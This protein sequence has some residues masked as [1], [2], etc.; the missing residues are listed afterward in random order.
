MPDTNNCSSCFSNPCS[1]NCVNCTTCNCLRLPEDVC[2]GCNTCTYNGCCDCWEC[3][4]CSS[5]FNSSSQ[6]C[7][8]CSHCSSCCQCFECE[9]CSGR[10]TGRR[11]G[12]CN[13]CSGCCNCDR[14]NVVF[15]KGPKEIPF[16]T[17]SLENGLEG[18]VKNPSYRFI[19]AE[20][21][22]AD[23]D[24]SIDDNVSPVVKRWGGAIVRDG[25][26][27]D[28]G[29]E[30]N[31]APANG[32]LFVKQ[33]EEICGALATKKARV[34]NSCGLHVHIDARDFTFYDI[35][36]L[37]YLYEKVEKAIY[38]IVAKSRWSSNYSIPCGRKYIET[39][40]NNRLPKENKEAIT[41]NIYG[42]RQVNLAQLKN[43]KYNGARYNGLNLHSWVY[44]GTI[45]ARMHHGTTS[46]E[47]IKNWGM[48][49]AGIL[50]YAFEHNEEEIKALDG[51]NPIKL[52]ISLAKTPE[53][54]K[55][56]LNRYNELNKNGGIAEE[57]PDDDDYDESDD[58][59]DD[60]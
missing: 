34:T 55:W 50:D 11:C 19:S 59:D 60:Q 26:L 44:R 39:L 13:N 28:T 9:G 53:N 49:W 46:A 10:R 18:H 54:A 56:I 14:N 25:S 27:P 47:K 16:L 35:R 52:L 8:N 23:T 30:I 51:S 38:G 58:S 45:E 32:D 4:H 15:V 36:K 5:R 33:I 29:F 24:N 3:S 48:M 31:T 1:G 6:A 12:R 43:D 17:S 20:I 22:V 41:K 21:E 42:N 2:T 37:A 7:N 57:L 40:E